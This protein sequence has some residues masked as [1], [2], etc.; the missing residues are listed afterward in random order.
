MQL[1]EPRSANCW[2]RLTSFLCVLPGTFI[3]EWKEGGRLCEAFLAGDERSYQAVADQLVL[4][5]QFF[6]FDGWLINIENSLSV[7]IA[8]LPVLAQPSPWPCAVP[9]L[10]SSASLLGQQELLPASELEPAQISVISQR[11]RM[12]S[13]AVSRHLG[14]L[15]F[16]L[17]LLQA[18]SSPSSS[19]VWLA[20]AVCVASLHAPSPFMAF[21]LSLI[22]APMSFLLQK[23][24]QLGRGWLRLSDS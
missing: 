20:R 2:V 21:C 24:G 11:H 1:Q 14:W 18:D 6:R 13:G 23:E 15:S 8:S 22:A 12:F 16:A 7:S 3:T 19:S 5:A 9:P 17:V 4:I 10:L